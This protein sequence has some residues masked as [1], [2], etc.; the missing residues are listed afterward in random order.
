M[1]SIIKME[2]RPRFS[3]RI[4]FLENYDVASARYMLK[5]WRG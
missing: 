4:V 3:R 2:R 1:Q 5:G